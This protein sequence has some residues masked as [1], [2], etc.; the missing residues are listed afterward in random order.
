ML[1]ASCYAVVLPSSTA[2]FA[3]QLAA[4]ERNAFSDKADT[5]FRATNVPLN[6]INAPGPVRKPIKKAMS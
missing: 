3:G 4:T 2:A 5:S 6:V 1:G